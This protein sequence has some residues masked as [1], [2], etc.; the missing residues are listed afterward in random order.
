MKVFDL[1]ALPQI[2]LLLT[3]LHSWLERRG[4]GKGLARRQLSMIVNVCINRELR[5]YSRASQYYDCDK[6]QVPIILSSIKN[7]EERKKERR[8]IRSVRQAADLK[9]TNLGIF[10]S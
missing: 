3:K 7:K 2:L 9:I 4:F 6:A 1:I 10:L 8:C 5:T